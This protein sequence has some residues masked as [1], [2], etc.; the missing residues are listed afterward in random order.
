MVEL[1]THVGYYKHGEQEKKIQHVSFDNAK[2]KIGEVEIKPTK[3]Q[4]QLA[5]K[6]IKYPYGVVEDVFVK[7]D[8]FIFPMDFVVMDMKKDKEVPLLLGRPFRKT[9][10]LVIDVDK[11]VQVKA[12]NDGVTFNLFKWS[13]KF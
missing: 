13:K 2:K 11:G 4:L 6:S 7:V 8:K 3:M 12:K 1:V 5:N 9:V 10:R